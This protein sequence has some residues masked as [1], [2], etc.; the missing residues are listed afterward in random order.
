[1]A[2]KRIIRQIIVKLKTS[3]KSALPSDWLPALRVFYSKLKYAFSKFINLLPLAITSN[4]FGPRVGYIVDERLA[5]LSIAMRSLLFHEAYEKLLEIDNL[6][7]PFDKFLKDL[8]EMEYLLQENEITQLEAIIANNTKAENL[9]DLPYEYLFRYVNLLHKLKKIRLSAE[10]IE[11]MELFWPMN[12][13]LRLMIANQHHLEGDCQAPLKVI[14]SIYKAAKLTTLVA[15]SKSEKFTI[16]KLSG[17]N[18]QCVESEPKVSVIL[19]AYNCESTISFA[20]EG[21]LNQTWKNLEILIVDD[22]STDSTLNIIHQYAKKDT[23][24]RFFSNTKNLG[25]YYSRNKALMEATGKY[26]TVNDAD[27]W[28]HPQKIELHVRQLE[29]SGGDIPN[30]SWGLP[31]SIDH[32]D[33]RVFTNRNHLN[34]YIQRN[35]SSLMFKRELLL[36]LGGWDEVRFGADS[37]LEERICAFLKIKKILHLYTDVPLTLLGESADSITRAVYSSINTIF[38][39]VRKEY[40]HHYR[41]WHQVELQQSEPFLNKVGRKPFWVPFELI[42][43]SSRSQDIDL[44]IWGDFTGRS[45]DTNELKAFI[46]RCVQSGLVFSYQE[47]NNLA[48]LTTE[49]TGSFQLFLFNSMNRLNLDG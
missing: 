33:E 10:V 3:I 4:L 26:V 46:E 40:M 43:G 9:Q 29:E 2:L 21:L 28:S 1:M 44:V 34:V 6:E 14:N 31:C 24:I 37:E 23:R 5:S 22:C 12:N 20:I 35:T 8:L 47:K 17:E 19:P 42:N 13:N 45:P 39:G 36:R 11:L 38:W 48:N 16:H 41:S 18:I 25:A 49:R 30:V 32:E 15:D 27:D 7:H